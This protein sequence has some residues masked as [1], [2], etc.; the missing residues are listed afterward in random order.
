MVF[1]WD[2]HIRISQGPLTSWSKP[3]HHVRLLAS[4]DHL[5]TMP[6]LL[7]WSML[8]PVVQFSARSVR[9]CLRVRMAIPENF[10]LRRLALQALITVGQTGETH[11]PKNKVHKTV[12]VCACVGVCVCVNYI[13]RQLLCDLLYTCRATTI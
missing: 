6:E 5:P 13:V 7:A 1:T 2:C 12:C 10:S 8:S 11:S 4:S 9:Y 3:I